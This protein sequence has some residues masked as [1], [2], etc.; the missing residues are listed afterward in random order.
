M[1]RNI[2]RLFFGKNSKTHQKK[3]SKEEAWR[4]IVKKKR[5]F[6]SYHYIQGEGIEIGGL[7]QPLK[8]Y[9]N[10]KVRYVDRL[11]TEEVHKFYSDV[12]DKPK[13]T[14]DLVD[15]GERL[16]KVADESCDFVIANHMIEHCRNPIGAIFHMLRVL[17]LEGVLYLAIPDKRFT[18]DKD[19]K[20]TPFEHLKRDYE[21]GPEVSDREHYEEW[22]RV[23]EQVKDPEKLQRRIGKYIEKK[24]NIHFHVWTQREIL[25]M[26]LRMKQDYD[27]PI[28]IEFIGKSGLEVIMVLRKVAIS[29]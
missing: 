9:H 5:Y 3:E 19:R 27:F 22:L 14:V 10:A 24:V 4:E 12:A 18:F 29:H 13:V 25:E 23:I 1:L 20:I 16:A 7:H 26:F 6:A 21:V 2:K 15:D 8:V 11:S 28:E 17:K